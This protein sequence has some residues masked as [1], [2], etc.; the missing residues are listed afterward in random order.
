MEEKPFSLFNDSM[1]LIIILR[2]Y[3]L[4]PGTFLKNS[5]FSQFQYAANS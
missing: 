3:S 4:N 2:F 1:E 5:I